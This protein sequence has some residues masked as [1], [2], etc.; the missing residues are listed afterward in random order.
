ML[1]AHTSD[2]ALLF[3]SMIIMIICTCILHYNAISQITLIYI[4]KLC[5][6]FIDLTWYS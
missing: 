5:F 2:S 6:R 3:E 1:Y 4:D